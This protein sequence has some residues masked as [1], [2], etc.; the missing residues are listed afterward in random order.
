MIGVVYSSK[1]GNTELL[2]NSLNLLECAYSLKTSETTEVKPVD[3]LCVGFWVMGG[4]CDMDT[5]KFLSTLH[6]QKLFLF[7]TSGHHRDEAYSRFILNKMKECIDDSNEIVGFYMCQGKMGLKDRD[8]FKNDEQKL[9]DFDASLSH[10][11]AQDVDDL[12]K[13][14]NE[15]L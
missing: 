1:T 8:H 15:V 2:A 11:D 7:G 14:I 13:K 3:M 6:N 4:N 12:L 10:P 9:R 5:R